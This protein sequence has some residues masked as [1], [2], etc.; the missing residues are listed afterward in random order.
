MKFHIMLVRTTVLLLM[1]DRVSL[2]TLQCG[3]LLWAAMPIAN[4]LKEDLV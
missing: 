2:S 1:S 3:S 4:H